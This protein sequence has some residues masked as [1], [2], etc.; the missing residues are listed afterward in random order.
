MT[1]AGGSGD[2]SGLSATPPGDGADNEQPDNE[3]AAAE[4]DA[5]V[6]QIAARDGIPL[7]QATTRARQ[8]YPD[9]FAALNRTGVAKSY[10]ELVAAEIAKG[11]SDTV[12]R[13]RINYAHP[14]LARE[15]IESIA[16]GS[17]VSEF[18]SVVDAIKKRDGVSRVEAMARARREDPQR[19]ERFQ[20]V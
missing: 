20:N 6:H 8:E 19:F 5:F 4:F 17:R 11:Y 13:Q 14:E 16:K 2:A 7:D 18:M 10:R 3:T 9:E 12:A 15:S 1:D